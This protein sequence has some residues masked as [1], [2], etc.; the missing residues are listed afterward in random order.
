[1]HMDTT[2]NFFIGE[3]EEELKKIPRNFFGS[4][5]GEL[6]MQEERVDGSTAMLRDV[7]EAGSGS[8]RRQG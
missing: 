1:M 6:W 7:G 8:A 4:V 5:S 3:S 2:N